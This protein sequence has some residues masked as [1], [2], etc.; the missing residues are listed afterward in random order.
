[1]TSTVDIYRLIQDAV[2]G[3][4]DVCEAMVSDED[5]FSD[6][7]Q[8]NGYQR[9]ITV[10]EAFRPLL[11]APDLMFMP[12]EV[13]RLLDLQTQVRELLLHCP[14]I[15]EE[16]E[17]IGALAPI[18]EALT[19]LTSHC[20]P[21]SRSTLLAVPLEAAAIVPTQETLAQLIN[22]LGPDPRAW[23]ALGS[24]KFEELLA[25]IWAGL[26]W[27]TV[28]TPP[29]NDGGFDVRAIRSQSGTTVCYLLEAKAYDPHRPVGVEIVRNLYGV[30]ERERATHGILATTSRFS[31]GALEFGRALRYRVSL[32]DFAQ[33]QEW[34]Q[35]YLRIKGFK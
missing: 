31:R 9:L 24:R 20:S 26:G 32:A 30:V 4:D 1:M 12:S 16:S 25:E 35:R 2:G 3:L 15:P 22:K 17:F 11:L 5:N 10:R 21:E 28:L 6:F 34:A 23:H 27:E 13:S 18:S 8:Y 19:Y 14:W 33:V 29:S 7:W